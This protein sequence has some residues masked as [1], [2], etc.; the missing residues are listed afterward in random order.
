MK[1][2]LRD[3]EVLAMY[4]IRGIQDYIF[5][6]NQI[7]EIIGASNL[8]ENIITD[9]MKAVAG[10]MGWDPGKYLTDW[11]R[12]GLDAVPAYFKDKTIQMQV[13]FIGGGNA[14]A[15]FRRGADCEAMNRRLGKYLLEHTYSLNL[16]AAVVQKTDNYVEDYRKIKEEMGR[17]KAVMPLTKPAGALPFMAADPVTGY[18][19]SQT[20]YL[21]GAKEYYCTESFHKREC[22]K[23]TT[24]RE[25]RDAAEKILDNMVTKKGDNSFLAAVHI[26][27]NNMGQRILSLMDG[28]TDYIE[29]TK[30]MRAIS[31]NIFNGFS[32]AY[33]EMDSYI[34]EELAD[35]IRPGRE[36]KL[37][38]KLI[39]AGDDITFICNAKA[40]IPAVE[41]FL[42]VVSSERMFS[43]PGWDDAKNQ[44]EYAF[45]ACAGIAY[46]NSHFPFSDAYLVAEE[47]C[48]SAKKRAKK[49]E[50]RDSGNR[51][52]NFFDFQICEHI[53]AA[54]L[55]EYR[56]HS[57]TAPDGSRLYMRP[58]YVHTEA[59]DSFSDLEARNGKY[60]SRILADNLA[61]FRSE[62]E[63]PRSQTKRLRDCYALGREETDKY[64]V[65]LQSRGR[66]LPQSSRESW[67]DAL[68]IMD[69][70]L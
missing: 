1:T 53:N 51:I 7:K 3:K 37:C 14:Y 34:E 35:Q 40:A 57:Y 8:V 26:D 33:A 20:E 22:F 48:A 67:F 54:D 49:E 27:G 43:K 52:G 38:R 47:C 46:F 6:T 9:G 17:I 21:D 25:E 28:K 36:G 32:K 55:D 5:R 13:L 44:A 68:E 2:E 30:T 66:A 12:E 64:I 23:R 19:L 62:K 42:C 65:F 61:Y 45:S 31:L 59:W 4:D 11:K 15:L 39:S 24:G 69:I 10:E 16:A 70:S 18:P 63:I 41:K 29:A 50:N 56:E 58:Y 60:S